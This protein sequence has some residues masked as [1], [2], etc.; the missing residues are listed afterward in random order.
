M[1]FD[2]LGPRPVCVQQ[3]I[4]QPR[5]I[6]SLVAVD[7]REDRTQ[8]VRQ[9][10]QALGLL[11]RDGQVDNRAGPHAERRAGQRRDRAATSKARRQLV[12]QRDGQA[13][14]TI[15]MTAKLHLTRHALGVIITSDHD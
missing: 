8:A 7:G 9:T 15:R 1:V 13:N 3:A 14:D 2:Q 10:P 6:G 5:G 4:D 11:V 12:D